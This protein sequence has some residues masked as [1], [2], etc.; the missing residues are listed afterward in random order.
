M[1]QQQMEAA[2]K[3]LPQP[4]DDAPMMKQKL[5]ALQGILDPLRKQ[6]PKMP[7]ASLIPSYR[8]NQ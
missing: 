2:Q 8:E 5:D 1:T 3:Q 4:G 6:V 7:G